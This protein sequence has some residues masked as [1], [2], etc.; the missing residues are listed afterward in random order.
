MYISFRLDGEFYSGQIGQ[1]EN[2]DTYKADLG[3]QL[4][5]TLFMDD[6][7]NWNSNDPVDKNIV[8]STG[9]EIE[10]RDNGF[11]RV[12]MSIRTYHS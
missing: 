6:D 8:R 2:T 5:F 9:N 7:A 1:V 10:R 11:E 12:P 4:S 3:E